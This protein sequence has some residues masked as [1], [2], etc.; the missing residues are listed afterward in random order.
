MFIN[1]ILEIKKEENWIQDAD[2]GPA[3]IENINVIAKVLDYQRI[4][5]TA[6]EKLDANNT[7]VKQYPTEYFDKKINSLE[8]ERLEVETMMKPPSNSP[9]KIPE[10]VML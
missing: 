6:V 1:C 4:C 2:F 10:G 7:L 5:L 9:K 8:C 3:V